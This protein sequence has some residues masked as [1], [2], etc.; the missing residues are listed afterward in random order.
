MVNGKEENESKEGKSEESINGNNILGVRHDG[1]QGRPGARRVS[2]AEGAQ[3]D[4]QEGGGNPLGEREEETAGI[5][6][7]LADQR[8][9]RDAILA[10]GGK[11]EASPTTPHRDQQWQHYLWLQDSIKEE[12]LLRDA[13]RARKGR[14]MER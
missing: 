11:V 12:I 9:A 10:N 1:S 5:E 14:G 2:V 3:R 8:A 4:R 7:Q 13:A 6:Q